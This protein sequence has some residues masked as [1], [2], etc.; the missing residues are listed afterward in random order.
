MKTVRISNIS[1]LNCLP[2]QYGL[3]NFR[4]S[5]EYDVRISMDIPSVCAEKIINKETD[6]GIVPVGA[7]SEIR[8]YQ[9]LSDY[10][11]GAVNQVR[12]VIIASDVPLNEIENL[13]PD[14]QS[15]T[16]N[17][18]SAILFRFHWKK[19]V[20]FLEKDTEYVSK[21]SGKT[22]G[23]IIG[24]RALKPAREFRYII[25]LS[26]EWY[27]FTG[28]PFVFALWISSEKQDAAFI[29]E[30]N[31]A[32]AKGISDIDKLTENDVFL[33]KYLK[34]YIDYSFNEEKNKALRL[35]LEYSRLLNQ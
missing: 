21:I 26:E 3:E 20:R 1:Y 33:R 8:D 24:D 27:K 32:L 11:I 25:D 7:L 4:F 13:Y 18:L 31:K 35:F 15:R 2:F 34:T 6:I 22:A 30:F 12:S 9:I 5:P 28:L 16:S 23:V 14:F 17:V 19:N 10:C 29:S